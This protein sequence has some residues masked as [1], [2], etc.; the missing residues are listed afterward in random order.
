MLDLIEAANDR[1]AV[2]ARMHRKQERWKRHEEEG[3][4]HVMLEMM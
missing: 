3:A 4:R 1:R 2:I